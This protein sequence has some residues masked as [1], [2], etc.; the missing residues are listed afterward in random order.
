MSTREQQVLK[1]LLARTPHSIIRTRYLRAA[2]RQAALVGGRLG[3]QRGVAARHC[4][5]NQVTVGSG[6]VGPGAAR[7]VQLCQALC[8]TQSEFMLMKFI[9]ALCR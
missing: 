9:A 3:G 1:Q 8:S 5:L 6:S 7:C 4:Q 2:L